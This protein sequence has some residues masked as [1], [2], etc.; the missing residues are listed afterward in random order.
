MAVT[1]GGR[2]IEE[3]ERVCRVPEALE[4]N[5]CLQIGDATSSFGSRLPK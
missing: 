2:R 1:F 4:R 3:K 5:Q